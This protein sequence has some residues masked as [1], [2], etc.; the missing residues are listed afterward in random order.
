MS[1]P[2]ILQYASIIQTAQTFLVVILVAVKRDLPAMFLQHVM[3]SMNVSK[4]FVTKTHFAAITLV[5]LNAPVTRAGLETDS[6]VETLTNV[7]V[8]SILGVIRMQNVS[9]HPAA[10]SANVS[11]VTPRL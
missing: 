4:K 11:A 2:L 1:V 5:H 9:T 6:F 7:V 10:I 3:T 8:L